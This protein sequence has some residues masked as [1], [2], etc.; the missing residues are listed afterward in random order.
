MSA[1]PEGLDWSSLLVELNDRRAIYA[2]RFPVRLAAALTECSDPDRA[3][4]AFDQQA[5]TDVLRVFAGAWPTL[6]PPRWLREVALRQHPERSNGGW[7]LRFP[8][9][10]APARN[11]RDRRGSPRSVIR[12]LKADPAGNA[13]PA[14]PDALRAR[15]APTEGANRLP[16]DSDYQRGLGATPQ[17]GHTT[18]RATNL[19][20]TSSARVDWMDETIPRTR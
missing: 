12:A 7:G 2:E 19:D 10:G 6:G 8:R 11:H 20:G 9:E 13:E 18:N 5:A 3:T 4:R 14:F 15:N 17:R 1:S 16:A